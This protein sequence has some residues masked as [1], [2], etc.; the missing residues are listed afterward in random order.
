METTNSP[1]DRLYIWGPGYVLP[2]GPETIATSKAKT[3]V[4]HTQFSVNSGK[5]RG[6][7]R[8]VHGEATL[9]DVMYLDMR[10][11][12]SYVTQRLTVDFKLHFR[13]V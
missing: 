11:R 13:L 5:R 7:L 3:A 9:P 10:Q 2:I 1:C 6:S 8:P 12:M 4:L